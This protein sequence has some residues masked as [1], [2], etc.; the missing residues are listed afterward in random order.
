MPEPAAWAHHSKCAETGARLLPCRS[1][2]SR[3]PCFTAATLTGHCLP[4]HT[5]TAIRQ[6]YREDDGLYLESDTDEQ[7]LIHI[8]FQNACRLSGLVIKSSQ[9][10][11]QVR[12]EATLCPVPAAPRPPATP[13]PSHPPSPPP[14]PAGPE[15]RKAVCEPTH[16]RVQ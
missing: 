4:P 6:G 5:L 9:S 14:P 7:L 16:H 12:A 13:S 1:P 2:L 8:P 10:P 3:P 11:E 15:T